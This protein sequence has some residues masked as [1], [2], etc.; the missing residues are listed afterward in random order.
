MYL[1]EVGDRFIIRW[2]QLLILALCTPRAAPQSPA[3]PANVLGQIACQSY[4]PLSVSHVGP[5]CAFPRLMSQDNLPQMRLLQARTILFS[6]GIAKL[7]GLDSTFLNPDY[8]RSRPLQLQ[9]RAS[10]SR[11][12]LVLIISSKCD[13]SPTL[14]RNETITSASSIIPNPLLPTYML[15]R[16]LMTGLA[17][18]LTTFKHRWYSLFL[19]E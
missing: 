15:S 3:L 5:A 6:N 1:A 18:P 4:H 9:W 8:R 19:R 7:L 14:P 2:M 10:A 11:V 13:E 16:R 17:L 12:S